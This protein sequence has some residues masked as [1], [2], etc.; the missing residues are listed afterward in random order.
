M[1]R[2]ALGLSL[3]LAGWTVVIL[4]PAGIVLGRTLAWRRFRGRSLVE[5]LLALP[6]VL[7]PTVLGYY[8]LVALGNASPL[9]QLYERVTGSQLVFTFG[10]LLLA[11]VI[12]NLPFAIQPMQRAFENVSQEV[13]DA[14]ACCG[15]TRW[16]TLWRIELP[17]AWPGVLSALVLTFAHTL[18]EFGV[19][20]MVG[21]NIPGE[22]RTI[23]VAIYDRVQA[24]DE[25]G[26]AV[27][28]ATL[29]AVCLAAIAATYFTASRLDRRQRV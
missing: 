28:S 1:D 18:G 11:S 20:L 10:G 25:H 27:M 14:A 22:T 15:L 2:E 19:V 9:G 17:L 16:R 4:L 29:L 5:G 8:L 13:R 21:G 24:F 23:A 7:P 6:L 12:F 3:R 26:A